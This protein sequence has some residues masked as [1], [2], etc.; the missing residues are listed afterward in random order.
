MQASD[1]PDAKDA[2]WAA[3]SYDGCPQ[4]K[5][6][7]PNPDW[8][9]FVPPHDRW[10]GEIGKGNVG[11]AKKPTPEIL[12]REAAIDERVKQVLAESTPHRQ[13]F[14]AVT[15]RVLEATAQFAHHSEAREVQTVWV[16]FS[17]GRRY[18][19]GEEPREIECPEN[20]WHNDP[21]GVYTVVMTVQEAEGADLVVAHEGELV[22]NENRHGQFTSVGRTYV[23]GADG[24][25]LPFPVG[26]GAGQIGVLGQE[27]HH[28]ATQPAW[29]GQGGNVRYS[30]AW[31][32]R[33]KFRP[34]PSLSSA[35]SVLT[36]AAT[37]KKR[38]ASAN[39]DKAL[40]GGGG[41]AGV[42]GGSGAREAG[43]RKS[44]RLSTPTGGEADGGE[45]GGREEIVVV[46]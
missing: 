8:D 24:E 32:V 27:V 45:E 29:K 41:A 16:N 37:S 17:F 43:A 35:Q 13:A 12:A 28:R 1:G 38:K 5:D 7:K 30:A 11:H 19:M 46:A 18:G 6:N 26:I 9:G 22:V 34:L 42:V 39:Q 2:E 4:K 20:T 3:F 10:V 21:P 14:E 25:P 36:S 44:P 31:W 33:V 15:A 23:K 40:A